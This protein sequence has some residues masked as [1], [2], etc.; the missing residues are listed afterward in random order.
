MSKRFKREVARAIKSA[1][2][3]YLPIIIMGLVR[4]GLSRRGPR[5]STAAE[6]R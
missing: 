3:A 5:A 1:L 6:A 2:I 4:R